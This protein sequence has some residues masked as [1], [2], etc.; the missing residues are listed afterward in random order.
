M[1]YALL[2]CGRATL[3][4]LEL[5]QVADEL[6]AGFDPR[7]AARYRPRYNLPPGDGHFIVVASLGQEFSRVLIAAKWGM[8]K[9]DRPLVNLRAETAQARFPQAGL[10]GVPVDGF[11]EWTG[12]AKQRKPIWY[13]N[14]DGSLLVLA[15]LYEAVAGGPPRF[16][17]LTRPSVGAVAQVHDRM[18]LV[19][20]PA[21]LDDWLLG[22]AGRAL[23]LAAPD[24][25]TGQPVSSRVNTPANDDPTCLLPEP[26]GKGTQGRLFPDS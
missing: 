6:I 20:D 10:C 17:V 21:R 18:P 13:R 26:E 24:R 16:S 23:D 3:T 15:G 25:L 2:M 5:E 19:L 4:R 1:R 14:P 22:R 12:S 9:G 8:P 11:F 7:D